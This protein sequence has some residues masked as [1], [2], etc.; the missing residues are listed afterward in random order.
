MGVAAEM[1]RHWCAYDIAIQVPGLNICHCRCPHPTVWY[2]WCK[3]SSCISTLHS[4]GKATAVTKATTESRWSKSHRPW[5]PGPFSPSG[6]VS[7]HFRASHRGTK[8]R[9]TTAGLRGVLRRTDRS[10]LVQSDEPDSPSLR[11]FW[12]GWMPWFGK[13]GQI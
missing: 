11:Q 5:L 10:T 3:W 6:P 1:V 4:T 2:L 9:V 7:N 12:N 13:D 8:Y